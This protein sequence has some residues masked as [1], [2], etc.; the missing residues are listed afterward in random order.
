MLHQVARLQLRACW[1][2]LTCSI[3]RVVAERPLGTWCAFPIDRVCRLTLVDFACSQRQK[4]P[5]I[6]SATNRSKSRLA[7]CD[8]KTRREHMRHGSCG[9][10][11]SSFVAA[12]EARHVGQNAAVVV[13]LHKYRDSAGWAVPLGQSARNAVCIFRKTDSPLH[14]RRIRLDWQACAI[15]SV[16]HTKSE[17]AS[18]GTGR[19]ERGRPAE[20]YLAKVQGPER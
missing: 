10:N 18:E 11:L 14:S 7:V 19:S 8:C 6:E 20:S 9:L 1:A 2:L 3:H 15:S 17:R 12:E 4:P 5:K 13:C 16:T